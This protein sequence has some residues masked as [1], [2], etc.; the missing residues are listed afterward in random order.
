MSLAPPPH[1]V[2]AWADDR[3]VYVELPLTSGTGYHRVEFPYS[4]SGLSRALNLL[5]SRPA[6][7]RHLPPQRAT[8]TSSFTSS[9]LSVA[10]AALAKLGL[11]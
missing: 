5:R 1:A 7:E 6:P 11:T 8:P 10:K 4:E 3:G 9:Q 2:L